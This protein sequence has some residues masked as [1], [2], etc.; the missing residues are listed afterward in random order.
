MNN[1]GSGISSR[2]GS[3]PVHAVKRKLKYNIE[4]AKKNKVAYSLVLPYYSLF[5]VFTLLPV[6]IS[7]IYSFTYFN[8]LEPPRWIGVQNYIN[9]FLNDDVFII[10][11]RNTLIYSLVT[12]PVS[13]IASFLFAWL[14]NELGRRIRTALVL[15]FYTP[16]IGG[17]AYLVWKLL[18]SSDRYG[19]INSILMRL[20]IITE[21][22]QWLTNVRYIM[23]IM[24]IVSLWMSISTAFL[25]FV[26]GLQSIDKSLLEQGSV[27]GVSN[28]WQ[29]L[30]FIILPTMRPM[31]MFGAVMSITGSF[32]VASISIELTG[33]PSIDYAGHTIVTHLMDYGSMRFEMGYASAIATTLFVLMVSVNKIVQKLLQKVGN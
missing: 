32:T 29:E 7:I 9:L 25:S 19:Y 18:F 17:N 28:R 11:L 4:R 12:G 2:T 3:K 30:W 6:A 31:L 16:S 21:P 26:A 33:F 13:Y 5:F 10:A 1:A 8:I 15:I 20:G 23:P 22:I 14:I 27:D 24:I